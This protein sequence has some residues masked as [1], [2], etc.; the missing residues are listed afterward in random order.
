MFPRILILLLFCLFYSLQGKSQVT[1]DTFLAK[2][3]YEKGEVHLNNYEIDSASL[4]FRKSL[5]IYLKDSITKSKQISSIYKNIAIS[6]C[7]ASDFDNCIKYHK[8]ALEINKKQF[9]KN[10]IKIANDY[11][12]L[13]VAYRSLQDFN[14]AITYYKK[15]EKIFSHN[16]DS[17]QISLIY[18]NIGNIHR[19]IGDFNNSSILYKKAIDLQQNLKVPNLR[20]IAG[21]KNNLGLLYE[22]N[23]KYGQALKLQKESLNILKSIYP[24]NHISIAYSYQNIANLFSRQKKHKQSSEYLNKTLDIFTEQFKSENRDF[25]ELYMAF[26]EKYFR[27]KQ[28]DLSILYHQKAEKILTKILG[29]ENHLSTFNKNN[30]SKSLIGAK[31]YYESISIL[32][33]AIKSNKSKHSAKYYNN[34]LDFSETLR[35]KSKS[36]TLLY[37]KNKTLASLKESIAIAQ[38]SDSLIHQIRNTLTTYSDKV[39]FAETA[40]ATY[41]TALENQYLLYQHTQDSKDLDLA[42]Y[43]S[44]QSKASGLQSLLQDSHAKSFAGLPDDIKELEQKLKTSNAYYHSRIT[45]EYTHKQPDSTKIA[46]YENQLFEIN[47]RQ[48]SLLEII[49]TAYPRYAQLKNQHQTT[50]IAQVQKELTPNQNLLSF[51]TNDSSTY[52]IVINNQSTHFQ[53]LKTPKLAA[54][55]KSFRNKILQKDLTTFKTLGHELYQTLIQPIEKYLV[56]DELIIL[57][58]GPLWHLNFDLLL[59]TKS[60]TNNPALFPYLIK[61]YVISYANSGTLLFQN[62]LQKKTEND[63]N[64]QECLAFSFSDSISNPS[65]QRIPLSRLRDA[66]TYDLPGTREEIKAIA[67]IVDGTYYYG[68]EAIE[69]NFKTNAKNYRILH[70]ALH[71]AV[72]NEQPENSK[73]FFTK[74]KDTI[75]DNLLYSHELFAMDLPAELA[76]LSA[77]HTGTGKIADGEGILSLGNAFRYAGTKSLLLSQWEVSDETTPTIMKSFYT[78]L[79]E[80]MTKSKALRQAKLNFLKKAN[81][82]LVHPFYWSSFYI[83]GDTTPISI[84]EATSFWFWISITMTIL[85]FCWLFYTYKNKN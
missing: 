25:A 41:A 34:Y 64:L 30:L 36:L 73:L 57:P 13:G 11:K 38:Q 23:R 44:E 3:H 79:A 58:D 56:G 75:E 84:K 17:S 39:T 66:A 83:L 82:N 19:V 46:T 18:N 27:E 49:N 48:D 85:L 69:K 47:R 72:D 68:K 33:K 81:P 9:G 15:A 26:G 40:K 5:K 52:A 43:Y 1:T 22:K 32:N 6:N 71:G 76:V 70:L 61:E 42:W 54:N 80:G 63:I 53:K 16:K 45:N 14:T 31:K 77:C 78:H 74:T 4:F 21:F 12:D 7:I 20:Y 35:L 60:T 59:K 55:I 2:K 65:S 8:K 67:D 37:K 50:T 28:F 10:H 24:K 29:K 62:N 51:V